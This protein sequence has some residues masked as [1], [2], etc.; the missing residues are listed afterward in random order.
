MECLSESPEVEELARATADLH[1]RVVELAGNATLALVAGMLHEIIVRHTS[2]AIER[3]RTISES[4][5]RK[6][7]R[8][9][10]RFLELVTKHDGPG[11]ENHWRK[12][13]HAANAALLVGYEG[14]KV[15]D[16]VH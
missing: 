8:S 7:S 5:Y 2:S 13:V 1:L 9:G 6:L 12:H 14:A 4:E 15:H 10:H 3:L 11:A 16:I